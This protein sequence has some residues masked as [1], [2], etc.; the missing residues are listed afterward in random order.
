LGSTRGNAASD[1]FGLSIALSANGYRIAVGATQKTTGAGYVRVLD[2]NQATLSWDELSNQPL[3]GAVELEKFGT[4]VQLSAD[5]TVLAVGVPA[6]G[7][8]GEELGHVK[9]LDLRGL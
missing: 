3:R 8:N 5:G 9:V 4:D 1:D 7:L 2:Y 6:G